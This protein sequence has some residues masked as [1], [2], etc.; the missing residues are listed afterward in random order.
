MCRRMSK[1]SLRLDV[2]YPTHARLTRRIQGK[3]SNGQSISELVTHANDPA[4]RKLVV[5]MLNEVN[6]VHKSP[7]GKDIAL[8]KQAFEVYELEA[9]LLI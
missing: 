4:I 8:T 6:A 5:D 3:S 9:K 1:T 2:Y 7:Q